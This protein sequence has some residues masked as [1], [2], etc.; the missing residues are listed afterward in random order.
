MV[1][2]RGSYVVKRH[3]RSKS[4]N[5]NRVKELYED[6]KNDYEIA[7]ELKCHRDS[8][9]RWRNING[10]PPVN[11]QYKLS[12]DL[13]EMLKMNSDGMDY[14][15]IARVLGVE[16]SVVLYHLYKLNLREKDKTTLVPS[17]LSLCNDGIGDRE[18]SAELNCSVAYVGH[19]RRM[20]HLSH[21]GIEKKCDYKLIQE[22]YDAGKNDV[23]IALA[24]GC[25]RSNISQWRARN[26]LPSNSLHGAKYHKRGRWVCSSQN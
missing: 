26:H 23:C 5:Y 10:L 19:V 17:I 15:E 16:R 14:K 6:H 21:N 20:H 4:I 3:G 2:Y 8:V 12:F 11:D 22:L 13:D 1:Q 18:I 9:R 24:A 7:T 25:E